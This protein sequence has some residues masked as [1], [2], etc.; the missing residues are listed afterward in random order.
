MIG[1]ALIA[2]FA[3]SVF[4][5]FPAVSII[6][7]GEAAVV[8][9][10]RHL[11]PALTPVLVVTP[12]IALIMRAAMIEVLESDYIET[13]RLSGVPSGGSSCGTR[14]PMHSHRRSR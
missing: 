13:A 10:R 2:L 1:L 5:V 8:Q 4:T 14:C 9:P 3:T 7:P 11:A 6:A 12:N